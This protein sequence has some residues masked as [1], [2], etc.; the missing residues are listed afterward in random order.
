M[1][2]YAE[3]KNI[4]TYAFGELFTQGEH[5][6]DTITFLIGRTYN[7]FDLMECDFAMRGLTSG[8]Y[9]VQQ[10]LTPTASEGDMISLDWSVADTFTLNS[11][12]LQLELRVSKVVDG[13]SQLVIKFIM[14]PVYVRPTPNG[15]NGPLP[16]TA[17]Q[18]VSLISA[19]ASAGRQAVEFAAATG[20]NAVE[21]AAADGAAVIDAKTAAIEAEMDAYPIASVTARLDQMEADTAIY[22]AR[23]EVIPVTR[24]QYDS[25]AHKQNALYVITREDTI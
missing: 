5:C 1:I 22:L 24:S 6:A 7:G 4:P 21:T 23:P 20:T 12:E 17:E 19:A 13:E 3:G 25:I 18:A 11:G 2:I 15:S 8:G 16:E 14:Q 10:D 9:E